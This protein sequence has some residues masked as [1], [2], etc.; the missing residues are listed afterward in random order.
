VAIIAVSRKRTLGPGFK[1]N[2]LEIGRQKV[3]S[4]M[5]HQYVIDAPVFASPSSG[6][7][8]ITWDNIHKEFIK[9]GAK[10]SRSKRRFADDLGGD[11][12]SLEA[13]DEGFVRGTGHYECED[14]YSKT[15]Y[16]GGFVPFS[17]HEYPGIRTA[18]L[19]G[20]GDTG[21]YSGGFGIASTAEGVQ[22]WK[23][24]RPKLFLADMGQFVGEIQETLPMLKT[25][26]SMFTRRFLDTFGTSTRH[27]AMMSKTMSN[28]WL[29]A[30][31]GWAPF[32]S[33]ITKFLK[34]FRDFDRKLQQC[35]RDNGKDIRR[36][37]ILKST[38]GGPGDVTITESNGIPG[39]DT[40]YVQPFSLY[41]SLI[42]PYSGHVKSTL[43]Y[44]TK[45]QTW[46]SA[47]FRYWVPDF[48]SNDFAFERILNFMRMYGLR[49]TPSLV[50]NLT[51]WSW[52]A[53]WFGNIG[54]NIDNYT[55]NQD[56]NLTAKYAFIMKTITE[57]VINES[58][59]KCG[60]R[61]VLGLRWRRGVVAKTRVHASQFGFS[62]TMPEFS[63]WHWSI[64]ASLGFSR[65]H[66]ESK[67]G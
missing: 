35:I 55:A 17:Q 50:Y 51:P 2:Q 30:Q 31:F 57:E 44:T 42:D 54:D 38:M 48:E 25:S 64:L 14:G 27:Q 23:K 58:R 34:K 61:E 65:L 29:N 6:F 37:G 40:V 41:N 16:D 26:A 4:K 13:S 20:M 60:G 47:C 22:A 8:K 1:F 56:D 63:A 15:T 66:I 49:I 21:R 12:S 10:I 11:F 33:D 46:F 36:R 43:S 67:R 62:L 3:W 59:V 18:D 24:F 53:D 5:S 9:R 7:Y 32:I 19:T 52:M 45:Y 39:W 28:H